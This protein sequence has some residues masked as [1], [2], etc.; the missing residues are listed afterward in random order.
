MNADQRRQRR[1]LV[2]ASVSF[3]LFILLAAAVSFGTTRS[4]DDF[5]RSG[6]HSW[7]SAA[8]TALAYD[9]SL[10]GS[11]ALLAFLFAAALAGFSLSGRRGP[12]VALASAMAGAVVLDN[13]L[14]YG[15]HRVRPDPFFGI[16][17]ETYSFPSGHVLFSSCFYGTLAG[18]LA[19]N[20][21]SVSTRTAIW[22][23]AAL[24]VLAIGVSRIY[25]G[26]HF[27]TDVIAGLLVGI[28]WL[29]LL[30]WWAIMP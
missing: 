18:V 5:V 10:L 23:A 26:V 25:L 29:S 16:A 1:A 8:L 15:F 22:A 2:C 3:I 14:K 24:L 21:R 30:R 6:I 19:A 17:P 28:C 20:V 11:V 9:F 7:A 13:L 12:A 4:F 27:P